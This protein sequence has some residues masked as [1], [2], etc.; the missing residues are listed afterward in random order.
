[1]THTN[2]RPSRK[3]PIVNLRSTNG[4]G[5]SHCVYGLFKHFKRILIRNKKTE[6]VVAYRLKDTNVVIVGRYETDCGGC[7][8]I[9][10]QD[11]VCNIVRKFSK[12]NA[13]LFEGLLISGLYSR[14]LDPSK[15][16]GG[17][18]WAYLDTS[19]K[20]CLKNI[21]HR[22]IANGSRE[23]DLTEK[24]IANVSNK[25]N[26]VLRTKEKAIADNQYVVDI[27]HDNSAREVAKL[28][29]VKW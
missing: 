12:S 16:L 19:L 1:M 6:K 24:T 15:E 18:T 2:K 28:L 20:Q 5:K 21:K 4:G 29:G 26:A 17:I 11:D 27:D 13:V 22:R 10:T 7:D 8:Q 23:V 3:F 9:P 14:Y 25:F